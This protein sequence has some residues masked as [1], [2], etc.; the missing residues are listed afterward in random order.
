M[1][2]VIGD[3]K[4]LRKDLHV[5][6]YKVKVLGNGNWLLKNVSFAKLRLVIYSLCCIEISIYIYCLLNIGICI[7]FSIRLLVVLGVQFTSSVRQGHLT[8]GIKLKN[9]TVFLVYQRPMN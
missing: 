3:F 7:C 2:A 5:F 9:M 6:S 8:Y 1:W 4:G